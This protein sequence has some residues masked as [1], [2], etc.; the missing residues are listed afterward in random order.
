MRWERLLEID[1]V[2]RKNVSNGWI[3]LLI[4]ALPTIAHK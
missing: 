1:G 4:F 3:M 2:E